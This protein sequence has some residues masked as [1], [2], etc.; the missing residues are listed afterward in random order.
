MARVLR[1]IIQE[2]CGGMIWRI[3]SQNWN[4]LM[5][6]LEC[7][8]LGVHIGVYHSGKGVHT[9]KQMSEQEWNEV[10]GTETKELNSVE[11]LN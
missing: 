1:C 5:S 10:H 7:I 3:D 11:A 8:N 6:L 2:R 9:I 4:N